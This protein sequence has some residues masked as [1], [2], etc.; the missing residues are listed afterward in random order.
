MNTHHPT[1]YRQQDKVGFLR[2]CWNIVVKTAQTLPLAGW[3]VMAAGA[4]L[5]WGLT[6]QD[7]INNGYISDTFEPLEASDAAE[8]SFSRLYLVTFD[9]Y[10]P[11]FSYGNIAT[12]IAVA[13]AWVA[14][15][16][17]WEWV[18]WTA[19]AS[20]FFYLATQWTRFEVGGLVYIGGSTAITGDI[21]HFLVWVVP[22]MIL[23][24]RQRVDTTLFWGVGAVIGMATVNTFLVSL[25]KTYRSAEMD[26]SDIQALTVMGVAVAAA[27]LVCGP[28]FS[29]ARTW[30]YRKTAFVGIGVGAAAL[31]ITAIFASHHIP[32]PP[33]RLKYLDTTSIPVA[34]AAIGVVLLFYTL[35]KGSTLARWAAAMALV[36]GSAFLY[37]AETAQK[38]VDMY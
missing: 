20:T 35:W 5:F 32:F 36:T 2:A 4:S 34:A 22:A 38:I 15:G 19:L 13:V 26:T 17:T 29:K 6:V 28:A 11:V 27:I 37:W 8:P 23:W 10:W 1:P 9:P 12:L 16:K 30:P 3:V 25:L 31:W 21:V 18:A 14:R 7:A 33:L 24:T